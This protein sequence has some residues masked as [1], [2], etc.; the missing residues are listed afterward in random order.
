MAVTADKSTRLFIFLAGLFIT[1]A[2][3]AGATLPPALWYLSRRGYISGGWSFL[4]RVWWT[5]PSFL[6]LGCLFAWLA[7]RG[8]T[9]TASP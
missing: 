4:A 1:N 8:A 6:F 5:V 7:G 3:I 9:E 2:L